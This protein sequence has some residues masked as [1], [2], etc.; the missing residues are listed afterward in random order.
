MH[1]L[2]KFLETRPHWAFTK[3]R[4]AY[5]FINGRTSLRRQEKKLSKI[6]DTKDQ[7]NLKIQYKM[8]HD[9]NPM[10]TLYADKS[11]VREF[12]TEKIGQKYLSKIYFDT[13][14]PEKINFSTLPSEFVIKA[15]HGSGAVI[16]VW[17]GA[18]IDHKLNVNSG[19]WD[20]F[21]INPRSFES[22]KSRQIMKKWLSQ[23]YYWVPGQMPEWAYKNIEPRVIIEEL[24]T[25]QQGRI[26]ED[27]KFYMIDGKCEFVHVRTDENGSKTRDLFDSSWNRLPVKWYLPNAKKE[28]LRPNH[29]E[30]MIKIAEELSK[31]IDFIR[32]DLYETK[33]GVKFGELTNYP[34]GGTKKFEPEIYN[35]IIGKSWTPKY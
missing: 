28:I 19:K 9:R 2:K 31:G 12:V 22:E 33:D 21:S 30:E 26:P 23:N 18:S 16:I 13:Q 7:F 6:R 4:W 14:E 17:D 25:D 29:L 11:R 20:V 35:T 10:L 27:F 1:F 3:I 15:S 5:F 24:F 8:A 34:D 32:V